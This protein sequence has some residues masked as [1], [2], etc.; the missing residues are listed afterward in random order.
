M[1]AKRARAQTAALF[2][3]FQHIQARIKEVPKDIEKLVEIKEYMQSVPGELEKIK[4][5][6][7]KCFDVY[8]IL[9]SFNHRFSKDDLDKKW[10]VYGGIRDILDLIE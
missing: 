9:E 6:M 8:K 2:N 10:I 5:E 3:Q 7:G 4:V 1:I